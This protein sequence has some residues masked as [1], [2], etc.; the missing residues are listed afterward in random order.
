MYKSF[1]PYIFKDAGKIASLPPHSTK[2][3]QKIKT[4]AAATE[5]GFCV[6][7]SCAW[8]DT[9]AS[10]FTSLS[11]YFSK[12]TQSLLGLV[13]QISRDR[14][15]FFSFVWQTAWLVG[16]FLFHPWEQ[17]R[18]RERKTTFHVFWSKS[19]LGKKFEGKNWNCLKSDS[20]HPSIFC[21]GV[22]SLLSL[23][24]NF[25]PELRG[26]DSDST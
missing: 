26:K 11:F 25:A 19:V 10:N 1:W 2:K 15:G 23:N 4:M 8:H 13:Q 5:R 21:F 6:D 20:F 14:R 22:L 9:I 3:V 12:G 16:A 17:R 18:K 24:Q 7:L